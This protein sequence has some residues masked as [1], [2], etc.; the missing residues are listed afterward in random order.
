[1][2][3]SGYSVT[4]CEKINEGGI[5]G[6]GCSRSLDVVNVSWRHTCHR[7]VQ[8]GTLSSFMAAFLAVRTMPGT[9]RCSGMH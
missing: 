6:D 5:L 4:V 8:H 2:S 7:I 1:M 3:Y 9:Q